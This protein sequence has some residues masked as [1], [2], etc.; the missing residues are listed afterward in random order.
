MRSQLGLLFLWNSPLRTSGGGNLVVNVVGALGPGVMEA[1]AAREPGP[2][3]AGF[4]LEMI[5]PVLSRAVPVA[6]GPEV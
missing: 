1:C 2:I 3:I 5:P 4:P 6:E